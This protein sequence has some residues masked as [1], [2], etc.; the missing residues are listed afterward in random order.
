VVS[1]VGSSGASWGGPKMLAMYSS[2]RGRQKSGS[3]LKEDEF[4]FS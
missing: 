3:I 1:R 4:V 2:V